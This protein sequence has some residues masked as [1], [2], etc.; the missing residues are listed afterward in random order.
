MSTKEVAERYFNEQTKGNIA[1]ALA[2]F[3][4]NA[5]FVGPMGQLPFPDGVRAYLQGF[6]ASFPGNR[7]EITNVIEAGEQVA[8]EGFWIGKHTGPLQLPDGT[9]IPATNKEVRAPFVTLLRVQN[10]KITS[11]RGY[12]DMAEFMSALA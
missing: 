1:S 4:A 10:D 2:C 9:T 6:Q 5:E 8:I 12:W 7:F 3:T 11:H